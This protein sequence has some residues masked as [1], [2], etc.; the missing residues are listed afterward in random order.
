MTWP[1]RRGRK[2][3]YSDSAYGEAT[4]LCMAAAG[5][6]RQAHLAGLIGSSGI[7]ILAHVCHFSFF[8]GE[9]QSDETRQ[10]EATV[11]TN[12]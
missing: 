8:W 2:Y 12:G 1:S 7:Q 4:V 11:F 3:T 9:W 5:N 10:K 6:M